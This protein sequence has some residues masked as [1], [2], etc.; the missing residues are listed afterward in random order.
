VS[1]FSTVGAAYSLLCTGFP[2]DQAHSVTLINNLNG[3]A[4][5]LDSAD[6][7]SG[8]MLVGN[9]YQE[10]SLNLT[11]TGSWI[12]FAGVGP[13]G[14]GFRFSNDPSARVR[15]NVDSTVGRVVIYRTTAS[16]YGSAQIYVDGVLTATMNNTTAAYLWAQP[17]VLTLTP[18]NH[19]VEL[20]NVGSTYTSVDAISILP[21]AQTMGVGLYQETFFDLSYTGNWVDYAGAGPNGGSFRFTN[22]PNGRVRFNINSSVG[23]LIF[24]RTTYS[25][26][27]STQIYVDDV[28][29]AT[30][31]NNTPA[32][33]FN[34]P[35]VLNVTPGNHSIELRNVGSTYSSVDAIELLPPPTPLGLGTYQEMDANL[36][37]TGA[38]TD[39]SGAGLNGGSFRFSNDP[40]ARVRFSVTNDVSRV[41]FYRTIFSIYGSTQIYV[42]DVL[43]ATMNNNSPTLLFNQPFVLNITPGNHT[44]ELRNVGSTYTS[45]DAI[46]LLGSP[47]ALGVGSIQE[48]QPDLTYTGNWTPYNGVEPKAGAFR[49]SNDPS[50]QMQFRVDNTVGRIV[51]YRTMFSIYGS[52]DIRVNG[53]SIGSMPNNSAALLWGQPFTI[54]LTPGNNLIEI[55]NT[56]SSYISVDQIDLLPPAQALSAGYYQETEPNFTYSGQWFDLVMG[57]PQGGTLRYTNDPTAR[58]RFSVNNTV[59]RVVFYRTTASMY[60]S[61]EIWVNGSL[62]QTM[63]NT[64]AAYLWGQPFTLN[65]T[66]GN[67]SIELRNVGSTFGSVDAIRLLGSSTTF[68]LG[69]F[70]ENHPDL[71]YTGTWVDFA[72]T[73]PSGGSFRYTNDPNGRVRFN[74]DNTVGRIIF[75]RTTA[76]IYGSMEIWVNGVQQTPNMPNT[77]ASYLWAQP[78]AV[79]LTPGANQIE[80]RNVGTSFG[81][82]DAFDLLP[83]ANTLSVGTV[84]ETNPNLTY[85][86]SWADFSGVG[87]LDGFFRFSN[88]PSARVRF[89]VDNSVGRVVIYRTMLSIY[90]Q[91]QVFVNNTLLTT[92]NSNSPALMWGQPVMFSVTPGNNTIELRNVGSTYT[93]VDKIV[94]LAPA[95]TLGTGTIEENA[96]DLTYTGNWS[97]FSG[98][99]PRNGAFRYTNDPTARVSFTVNSSVERLIFYRTM[100]SIY[101]SADIY[102]NGTFRTTLPSTFPALLWGQPFMLALTPGTNTIELR[103]TSPNYM[104]VDSIALLGAA[105]TLTAGLYEEGDPGFTY[106]GTWGYAQTPGPSGNAVFYTFTQNATVTFQFNGDGL[107]FYRT[108]VLGAGTFSVSIDGGTP[109]VFSDNSATLAWQQPGEIGGLT[110]GPHTAVVTI[111]SPSTNFIYFDAVRV[112]NSTLP[113]MPGDY[114]NTYP[115][116]AYTAGWSVDPPSGLSGGRSH[117]TTQNGQ[118]MSFSFTGTGF[119]IFTTNTPNSANVEI[120]YTLQGGSPVCVVRPTTANPTQNA[121]GYST[122]GLRQ[123]TYNVTVRHQGTA[124]QLL[125]VD[126]LV[127]LG[128]LPTV[129]Q[130]GT[131]EDSA[132]DI[133]YA[134]A[135]QWI[136]YA[137][138]P[139]LGGT[140]RGTTQS[141]ALAQIRFNGNSMILYQVVSPGTSGNTSLC[142]T[143]IDPQGNPLL[144]CAVFSQRSVS[145]VVFASPIAFYGFGSGT[146]DVIIENRWQSGLFNIDR[147]LI[148]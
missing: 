30:M 51:F 73:G 147:I 90:G 21:P 106:T 50:A 47:A 75:Y 136:T 128:T 63:N 20:R 77:T 7:G 114:Q 59:S 68:G 16:I 120:C 60:G 133:R 137:G 5:T 80:L 99:G 104:S 11:Y 27:G 140:L 82:L 44:I 24:Y 129:L 35:Y 39:Y 29:T 127:V 111:T 28:L 64:T 46:V 33:L 15:F 102:V 45:V 18:G 88:D 36:V 4:L 72:G 139:Y 43:T 117:V 58:M 146:H 25:I 124:G 108:M 107:V 8:Q 1:N 109:V 56:S 97:D 52:A 26:Y 119:G 38:W 115:G 98:V 130:P 86:G 121:V 85:F 110:N 142:V 6:V 131:Y 148:N 54:T 65:L 138:T 32:L 116:L 48:N 89:T 10:N 9:T 76:S 23:R 74:V 53:T 92:I 100:L 13:L 87:P 31:N 96:P 3:A 40:A 91:T 62:A 141:G 135:D 57:G 81:S 34:Q 14:G 49:Y 71:I 122:Y 126:S 103:N 61:T 12:D 22:D 70:Q 101:G 69:S 93:S 123:G 2:P 125:Y 105:P 17:Y 144:R 145:T 113:I 132:P 42:D 83:P 94:L 79:V 143:L 19:T 112:V 37:Y 66:P 41:V 67:N 84:Q 134:P 78:F 95:A 118:Q 55:R